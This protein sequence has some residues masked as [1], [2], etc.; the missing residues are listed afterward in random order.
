M[1]VPATGAGSE[2]LIGLE[3]R[4]PNETTGVPLTCVTAVGAP[5]S[6]TTTGSGGAGVTGIVVHRIRG[7]ILGRGKTAAS[8]AGTELTVSNKTVD[9]SW[10]ALLAATNCIG[11]QVE[12][13]A[14]SKASV[15]TTGTGLSDLTWAGTY[16]G[17]PN[18]YWEVEITAN[19][20]PDVFR[21]RKNGGSWTTGVNITG[22]AQSLSDGVTVAFAATVGHTIGDVWTYTVSGTWRFIAYVYGRTTVAYADS[23]AVGSEN[24]TISVTHGDQTATNWGLVE[25]KANQQE[26]P[27]RDEAVIR[28]AELSASLGRA[29]SLAGELSF[30]AA[31]D[32]DLR[33]GTVVPYLATMNGAPAASI[34]ASTAI[35]RCVFTPT[36]LA[37]KR[38]SMWSV[39]V[40][41]GGAFRPY[42][43]MGS[44]YNELEFGPLG[45]NAL[46]NFKAKGVSRGDSQFGPLLP[47]V[48]VGTYPYA[49]VLKGTLDRT[50][51]DTY[52]SLLC[53]I[54]T[55]PA[56][57]GSTAYGSFTCKVYPPAGDG[58]A[59]TVYYRYSDGCVLAY[60]AAEDYFYPVYDASGYPLGIDGSNNQR[61]PLCISFPGDVSGLAD[62]DI[63]T[64][65][66]PVP[67]PGTAGTAPTYTAEAIRYHTLEAFGPAN[68]KLYRGASSATDYLPMT[69]TSVKIMRA[70]HQAHYVGGH[71]RLPGSVRPVGTIA[72]ELDVERDFDASTF[73][74]IMRYR[75][76]LVLQVSIEGARIATQPT[77][78]SAYREGLTLDVYRAKIDS[79]TKS[80]TEALVVEKMKLTAERLDDP[81]AAHYQ[82]T[83]TSA[84]HWDFTTIET[85]V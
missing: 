79:I 52:S 55:T 5:A 73:E 30:P 7:L 58:T 51:H 17:E 6:P 43:R 60:G 26:L 23:T 70:L 83:T 11:Y 35:Q 45:G 81:A 18:D 65:Y 46:V 77:T 53:E 59:I 19:G 78:Y 42:L 62:G 50:T 9:L 37:N 47:T 24:T 74:D 84:Q 66:H 21:W 32:C 40:P 41:G 80:V 20:T 76:A 15:Q 48:V 16:T 44:V 63:F 36:D 69:A 10:V 12:R 33:I 14:L 57:I 67:I 72:V 75:E 28:S 82:I 1:G 39:N 22:S 61:E 85:A 56:R 54:L 13:A 68:V 29:Q 3:K 71:A 49:P 34:L 31:Q 2:L 8:A 25:A 27:K 64:G 4:A 38:V